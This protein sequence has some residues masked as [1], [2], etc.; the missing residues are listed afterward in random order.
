M[1]ISTDDLKEKEKK[2]LT[3]FRTQIKVAKARAEKGNIIMQWFRKSAEVKIGPVSGYLLD[4]L[5]K[6]IKLI[7]F[8]HHKVM[9]DG[10]EEV[11][12]KNRVNHI[13]IDGSTSSKSRQ[14]A[15]T[16]FQNEPKFKVA[17][18]SITACAT[19]LNLT[20]ATMVIFAE[21]FWNPGVLMQV[22][23]SIWARY[24]ILL[25]TIYHPSMQAEDR[26]HRIGQL[27]NVNIVYLVARHTIDELMWPLISKKLDILNKAGLS[28]DTFE[29]TANP[30]NLDPDQRMMDEFV[31]TISANNNNNAPIFNP[32]D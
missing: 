13:R 19:G 16:V 24:G 27:E 18:L 30:L 15:C 21:M 2:Q 17:L 22:K 14:E 23:R 29:N 1:A 11:L 8:C 4:M 9:M 26:V 32:L 20:A 25:T 10:V 6:D 28:R 12:N 7:C 3:L 31:T 5:E